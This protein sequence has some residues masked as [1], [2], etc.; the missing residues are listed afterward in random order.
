MGRHIQGSAPG[1]V[2]ELGRP[3]SAA[4]SFCEE[5]SLWQ[6]LP[7]WVTFLI[8]YGYLCGAA[9]PN[10]RRIGI[11]SMPGDS[12]G[13][14]L[15]A[16]GAIRYRLSVVGA[17]D[18][19][20][21]FQRLEQ[22]AVQRAGTTYLRHETYKGRFRIINGGDGGIWVE[23]A[24]STNQNGLKATAIFPWNAV[25][26]Q[27]EGEAPVLPL[28]GDNRPYIPFYEMLVEGGA[29]TVAS[30][31]S[32]S[33]S[34]ISLAG[35]VAGEAASRKTLAAI[36]FRRGSQSIDLA[37]LITVHGWSDGTVSRVTFFNTRTSQFDRCPGPPGLVVADGDL[38]LHRVLNTK[39]FEC[40]HVV[41][42]I[43]RAIERDRLESLGNKI[44]DLA[45]WYTPDTEWL[46][47]LLPAP[48]GITASV[49]K[50]GR[51]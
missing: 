47:G 7:K 19:G 10:V 37:R 14:G 20:S 18:C 41:G 30:N 43:H 2:V 5:N 6:P 42:V 49:L 29:A 31:F 3:E 25:G 33:D 28:Q 21:H 38:A 44:A 8:K 17:D 26:W 13:A 46:E 50:R 23:R 15:V 11:V 39:E 34:A 40:S 27:I 32:R 51:A 4:L 35:R 24:T 12:A 9:A 36:R 22:L 16:L 1:P 45:Q 48:V